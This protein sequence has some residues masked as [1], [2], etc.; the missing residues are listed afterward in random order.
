MER[1]T[2]FGLRPHV[3]FE[4]E[5]V[6]GI[7]SDGNYQVQWAPVW[8]SKFHLIGCDHLIQEF[9]Q[10]QNL[11]PLPGHEVA[12]QENEPLPFQNEN[13]SSAS[14]PNHHEHLDVEDIKTNPDEISMESNS[15]V[16]RFVC[17]SELKETQN[18]QV[19][20]KTEDREDEA[21]AHSES[22]STLSVSPIC[23]PQD[24]V[25]QDCVLQ[26]V[27]R[28]NRWGETLDDVLQDPD[29][30]ECVGMQQ[31]VND[32]R[33][34][35][36]SSSTYTTQNDGTISCE[37]LSNPSNF[38][39]HMATH[40]NAE[41][42]T[43]KQ[44]FTCSQCSYQ[45]SSRGSLK[46]HEGTHMGSRP[47]TCTQCPYSSSVQSNLR[48]HIRT[49]TGEKPYTCEVC[50]KSFRNQTHLKDHRLIHSAEKPF[51]C[52]Y[53]GE[54]FKRGRYLKDHIRRHHAE[55][56]PFVCL[57]CGNRYKTSLGLQRHSNQCSS[58]TIN[59]V[60]TKQN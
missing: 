24:C 21:V 14:F 6:V 34:C 37:E 40:S 50:E 49:H 32:L 36:P 30:A 51:C 17:C 42:C 22:H 20:V 57:F 58:V 8:V 56:G 18:I 27:A 16:D 9:L 60:S 46:V 41:T 5:K 45:S 7:S 25:P 1:S 43:D 3:S 12:V 11:Q 55:D 52:S 33:S 38:E 4:V 39:A 35:S 29:E 48:R 53:C 59:S 10:Q 26:S 28:G 47:Y 54:K 2:A 31:D 19:S 44:R 23:V 15:L 13:E